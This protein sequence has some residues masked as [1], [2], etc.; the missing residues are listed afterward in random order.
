MSTE[1]LGFTRNALAQSKTRAE[2]SAALKQAGWADEEVDTAL[3]SFAEVPFSIPVPKPKPYLSAREVFLYLIMF[4]ALYCC[5]YHVGSLFFDSVNLYFPDA[6]A[7]KSYGVN[8]Q[9]SIRL[10]IS[11]LVVSLPVFFFTFNAIQR[12]ITKNPV[13]RNSRP[14]KWLTYLT[15]FIASIALMID[16]GTLVYHV[17]S[18]EL[19]ARFILKV[20]IIVIIA[21]GNFF[22]FLN[23]MRREEKR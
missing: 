11:A 5:S 2:I 14:R 16:G 13:L 19:T 10:S 22:Y 21:G 15:L 18:G 12:T 17:L 9:E 20:L 4:S 8:Y 6:V 1:L 7:D 23:D 3:G